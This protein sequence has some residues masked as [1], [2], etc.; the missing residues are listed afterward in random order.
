MERVDGYAPIAGYALLGNGQG[1]ALVG[2][3]GSVDWLASPSITTEPLLGAILD[4]Q[5]GGHFVVQPTG[6]FQASRKYI[7]STMVLETTF[8]TDTGVL[9]VT[10]AMTVGVGCLP[11]NELARRL[12]VP[13]G[14]VEVRWEFRPGSR[15]ASVRPWVHWR[16]GRPFVLAGDILAT[17]VA[18]SAGEEVVKDG[19]VRGSTVLEQGRQA[20]LCVVSALDAQ[21]MVPDA[22]AIDRRIDGTVEFWRE[23]S[24][25]VRYDGP[26]SEQLRRSI[27]TIAGLRDSKTGALAAA[28]TTSLPEVIGKSRNFDYRFGWV[29]DA[30]FMLEAFADVELYEEM[31]DSL[32][33]LLAGAARTAPDIHVFYKLNGEP[34]GA[35]EKKLEVL[36]GYRGSSPVVLGNNAASQRQIGAY[37]DLLGAVNRHVQHGAHLNTETAV[38]LAEFADRLC[39]VWPLPGAGLWEL[40]DDHN[41]TS[42]LINSWAALNSAVDLAKRGQLADM[43]AARWGEVADAIHAWTDENCWS[44]AKQSYTFYAGT[45]DLDASV[46]LAARTGYLAGGDPRLSS[47][48][49]AIRRELTADGPWLYRYTGADREEHAFVCCTFWMI[50]ALAHGG[51]TAEAKDLLDA[52][53]SR[54]N[55]VDLWS[56]EIDPLSGAFLGNFPLGLSHLSVVGAI[57]AYNRAAQP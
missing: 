24:Q 42:S 1:C 15:L 4:S 51:R 40:G 9:K 41:Y 23:W 29:R 16:D 33:W 56:E 52:A 27:L 20:L 17:L 44:A 49:D 25:K 45:D 22:A 2:L 50:E 47:T 31:D 3:D 34:A 37:G 36:D 21:L 8:E 12:E 39:D 53:L 30:S 43:H 57:H 10:D 11:W 6:R 28:P 26:Y 55:D 5:Q 18:D 35:E 48:I 54:S 46:L 13:R 38:M 14:S 19:S 32:R 7:D